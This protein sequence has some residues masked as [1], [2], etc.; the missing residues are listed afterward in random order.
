M[1]AM[2]MLD[3]NP[4]LMPYL[5][6]TFD[7]L[8]QVRQPSLEMIETVG[9]RMWAMLDVCRAQNIKGELRKSMKKGCTLV[10]SW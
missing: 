6:E 7:G 2:D 9:E 3:A 8:L 5:G 4:Q 10:E 1:A